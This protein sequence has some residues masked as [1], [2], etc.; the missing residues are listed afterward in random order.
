MPVGE[1]G[2]VGLSLAEVKALLA[3]FKNDLKPLIT[4]IA[5]RLSENKSVVL[6]R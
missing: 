4:D 1:P 2:E 3:Q 5:E 6:K